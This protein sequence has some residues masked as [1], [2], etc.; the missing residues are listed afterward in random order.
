MS[1]KEEQLQEIEAL[2]SIY[3]DEII[4]LSEDPF[5]K[6][7]LMVKPTT[8]DED[9]LKPFLQ[10]EITFHENYPEQAPQ[11]TIIDSAN[12]DD[13]SAFDSEIQKICEENLGMPVIFTLASDLSEKLSI[14]SENRQIRQ[15]EALERRQREEEEAEH[16]RFEGTRVT[17]E[18]FI[19]W[20]V[21]FDAEQNELKKVVKVDETE[22]KKLTGRQLFEKDRSL[23][24]SD[25]QFISGE[26]GEVV[27]VDESLFE[28]MLDLEL[29]DAG[30]TGI[31]LSDVNE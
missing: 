13:T 28:D 23:Y 1:A 22:L 18:S 25:I 10:L 17:V 2:N 7:T 27:E 11:I 20:K 16:K 4:V 3:P 6:F 15:R 8:N 21:K 12:V 31:D 19:K 5:P 26:G 9:S 29:D 30:S 14:Q 24:D